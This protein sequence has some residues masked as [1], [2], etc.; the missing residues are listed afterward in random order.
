ML[1]RTLEPEVMDTAEEAA[2]YDAMDHSGVNRVFAGDFVAAL[3][4]GLTPPGSPLGVLDVGTGTALIPIELA[5]RSLGFQITA[6]DLAEEMLVLGR[7]NVERAGYADC[8][9]LELVDAKGLPFADGT[10]D[11]V[12]SNSI[13]HHIPEPRA[14]FAEMWRVLRPGGLMFVRDL[15]RPETGEDVERIVATY[16]GNESPRQQQLFRQSLHAALT[17]DEVGELLAEI[18]IGGGRP[19]VGGCGSVGDRPQL[20]PDRSHL[21]R[22]HLDRS[23][24]DRAR[25]AAVSQTSDRHWTVVA[26]RDV[27]PGG[28][29]RLDGL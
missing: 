26:W 9:S 24:L 15:L 28:S 6:I 7:R 3:N 1:P 11:A 19:A 27:P 22:S 4:R 10:F 14:V 8:I 12:M 5:A 25:P 2:D 13:V 21:D 16:A 23:H 29:R 20:H 17:V 18:G